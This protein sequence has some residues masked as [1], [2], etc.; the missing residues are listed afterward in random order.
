MALI[1]SSFFFFFSNSNKGYSSRW[2]SFLLDNAFTDLNI[3]IFK[4]F[5]R[6]RLCYSLGLWG[7][8]EGVWDRCTVVKFLILT[9]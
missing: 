4:Y 5:C 8:G 3:Q 7:E 1:G 2:I 6:Q 9:I